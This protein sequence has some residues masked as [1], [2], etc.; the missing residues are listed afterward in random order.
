MPARH[1]APW[2]ED[3]YAEFVRCLV[4]GFTDDEVAR[5]LGRSLTALGARAQLMLTGHAR[6]AD[7]LTTLRSVLAIRADYDWRTPVQAALAEK[8]WHL[9]TRSE[10]EILAQAWVASIPMAQLVS[11]LNMSESAIVRQLLGLRLATSAQEILARLGTTPDGVL[12]RRPRLAEDPAPVTVW[13]LT[14]VFGQARSEI[15]VHSSEAE[16]ERLRDRTLAAHP[17]NK[18]I[19]WW[20]GERTTGGGNQGR[21]VGGHVGRPAKDLNPPASP[22]RV[23]TEAQKR[24]AR[25]G[26]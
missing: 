17:V 7:A 24:W 20:I 18:G 26:H 14:V 2:G 9:W 1:G 8:G 11:Q 16:A 21:T 25:G 6:R 10:E 4:R 12:A 19:Q 15:S 13:C 5:A 23:A 22:R 3:D